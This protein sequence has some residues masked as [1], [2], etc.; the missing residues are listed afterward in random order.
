VLNYQ[1][2]RRED[3]LQDIEALL[4]RPD[5]EVEREPIR[6]LRTLLLEEKNTQQ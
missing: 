2:D 4:E 3:A 1:T 5:L 6:Q